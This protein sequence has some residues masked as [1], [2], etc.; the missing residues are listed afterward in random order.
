MN[1]PAPSHGHAAAPATAALRGALAE[2]EQALRA[3][4]AAGQDG[5]SLGARRTEVL[6]GLLRGLFDC[7]CAA[8]GVAPKDAPVALAAAGSYGRGTLAPYS[9]V[10]VRLLVRSRREADAASFSEALLY[11]MWDAKLAVGHQLLR[12]AEVLALAAE[13]LATATSLLDLR[14]VAGDGAV[15]LKLREAYA[16]S[17]DAACDVGIVD[18]REREIGR[19]HV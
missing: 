18:G 4:L 6:D 1:P 9:D 7:V 10:D 5:A 14:H 13:D 19:A 12:P 15:T 8:L 11:P 3:R 16:R 2:A 17:L